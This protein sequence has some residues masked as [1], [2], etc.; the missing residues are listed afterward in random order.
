MIVLIKHTYIINWST[1]WWTCR[2]RTVLP[3]PKSSIL[4]NPQ[5]EGCRCTP[6]LFIASRNWSLFSTVTDF[7]LFISCCLVVIL[8]WLFWVV[9][10]VWAQ[11]CSNSIGLNDRW[12]WQL[13]LWECCVIAF[14]SF[15]I[16]F[17]WLRRPT[18]K[19]HWC[20]CRMWIFWS[21]VM[22]WGQRGA[23]FGSFDWEG[24]VSSSGMWWLCMVLPS[25]S[26]L[27]KKRLSPIR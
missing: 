24:S 12:R 20:S 7:L 25:W 1:H 16:R 10:E 3:C 13:L 6:R 4:A 5:W 8:H 27:N 21:V 23:R 15:P 17:R 2:N 22:C 18:A 19:W 9:P 26:E 11:Q 14:L